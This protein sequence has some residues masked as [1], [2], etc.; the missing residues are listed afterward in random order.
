MSYTPHS[1]QKAL[2]VVFRDIKTKLSFS[3]G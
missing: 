1:F 3:Y 2:R